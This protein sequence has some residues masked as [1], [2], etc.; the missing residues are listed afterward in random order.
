M[1]DKPSPDREAA[2]DAAA[3]K[4][5]VALLRTMSRDERLA[6]LMRSLDET[7]GARAPRRK[8]G[9]QAGQPEDARKTIPSRR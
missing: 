2:G 5:D 7:C 8:P 4:E 3:R 9:A 1:V 6:L